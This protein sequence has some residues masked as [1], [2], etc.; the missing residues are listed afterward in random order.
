[1]TQFQP[2]FQIQRQKRYVAYSS[3]IIIPHFMA[4]YFGDS[5]DIFLAANEN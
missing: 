1:M 3:Y 4:I 5:I 2:R